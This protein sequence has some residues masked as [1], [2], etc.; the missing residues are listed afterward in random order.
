VF[1]SSKR[2]GG[3][4]PWRGRKVR[5][6]TWEINKRGLKVLNTLI[7]KKRKKGKKGR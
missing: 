6:F 7:K 4:G 3:K 1:L 5:Y 2:K